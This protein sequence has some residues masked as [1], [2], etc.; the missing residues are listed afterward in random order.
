MR[1]S[2]QDSV[3]TWSLWPSLLIAR[4]THPDVRIR[5]DGHA[6]TRLWDASRFVVG[7]WLDYGAQEAEE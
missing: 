5:L 4:R 2:S 3:G 6:V 1:V 7:P